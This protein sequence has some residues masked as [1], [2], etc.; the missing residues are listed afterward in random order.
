MN[1]TVQGNSESLLS[2]LSPNSKESIKP[3]EE[4]KI[5][6]IEKK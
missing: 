5:P 3:K 6:R 2:G 4:K 1:T